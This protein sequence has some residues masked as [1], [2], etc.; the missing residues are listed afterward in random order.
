MLVL[1]ALAAETPALAQ[2][3][4]VVVSIKPI[5]SLIAGVMKGIGAPH[6]LV[7]GSASPHIFAMR[8][9]DARVL[10]K[11]DVVFWIG[12]TVEPYLVKPIRSIGARA[13]IVEL[14]NG[15][16]V[17][18]LAAREGGAW[19]ADDNGGHGHGKHVDGHIW[20]DPRNAI[21]ITR[22]AEHVLAIRD[23]TNAPGYRKNAD[24]LADRLRS[25]DR[26]LANELM[27]IKRAPYV[28]F[29]DAYQY[30]ERHFGLNAVGSISA[31]TGRAP[32]AR[33][34]HDLRKMVINSGAD[35]IFHE[36]QF[37]PKLVQTL[38]EGTDASTGILDPMG[39][40]YAPGEDAYFR[41]MSDISNAL[42]M[43]LDKAD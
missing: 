24:D 31:H 11:A 5:H 14:L 19:E 23:P 13:H 26:N 28:V 36:P 12:E 20:L 15:K 10:E 16:G 30:F 18:V 4:N 43:C 33:R 22:I 38:I 21:A 3:P 9:S 25:F 40:H 17:H 1:G 2:A 27:P 29:H 39:T 7:E 35:C 41:I 8:P 42:V 6:L 32:G 34:L 37:D